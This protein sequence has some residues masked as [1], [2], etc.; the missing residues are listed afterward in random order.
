[1][2]LEDLAIVLREHV[3]RL[4]ELCVQFHLLH[5][6]VLRSFLHDFKIALEL[7]ELFCPLNEK[8]FEFFNT[9]VLLARV[10][11]VW[12]GRGVSSLGG[13]SKLKVFDCSFLHPEVFL[14]VC[15]HTRLAC[16]R[17]LDAGQLFLL[18]LEILVKTADDLLLALPVF[19]HVID[20]FGHLCLVMFEMHVP[21]GPSS[22]LVGKHANV[23]H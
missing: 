11:S 7:L 8:F 17:F 1:L 10:G 14:Q 20:L 23:L 21:G 9:P 22:N 2:V 15:N 6:K 13:K 4:V 3:Q 18:E 5:L 19:L 16:I 12:F